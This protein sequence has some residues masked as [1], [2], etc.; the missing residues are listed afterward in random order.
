[1]YLSPPEYNLDVDPTAISQRDIDIRVATEIALVFNNNPDD[2][3]I[4]TGSYSIEALTHRKVSHN[5]IDANIFTTEIPR[6]LAET[7]LKLYTLKLIKQTDSRL[8]Y[9]IYTPAPRKLELQFVKIVDIIGD[10]P[11][12]E[13]ALAD[14]GKVPITSEILKDSSGTEFSFPVKTL[15]YAIATWALR[16]SNI[17]SLQKREIR[18]TDINHFV[19][20]LSTPHETADVITAITNHPQMPDNYTAEQVLS[21]TS[22]NLLQRRIAYNTME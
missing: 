2:Y 13:F 1:M 18:M 5:D 19:F 21:Q 4:L 7:S 20:L 6:A 8:E 11:N 9:L 15:S 16:I 10:M 17:A 12:T 3:F 14:K 22:A